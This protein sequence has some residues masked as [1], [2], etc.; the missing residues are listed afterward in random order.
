M[1][2]S[3]LR[4]PMTREQF[5]ARRAALAAKGIAITGDSG[6]IDQRG[7][8]VRYAYDGAVLSLEV[9]KKPMLV[10]RGYVEGKI[11]EWFQE[12]V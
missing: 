1:A 8:R 2:N 12:A 5:D 6:E 10:T 11:T 3:I 9:F 4:F 7:V